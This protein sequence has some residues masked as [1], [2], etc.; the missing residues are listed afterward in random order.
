MWP[1]QRP[2]CGNG[3]ISRRWLGGVRRKW[4]ENGSG[5]QEYHFAR[6]LSQT[7]RVY[8]SENPVFLGHTSL[9][10]RGELLTSIVV[11]T[12]SE[13]PPGGGQA[14]ETAL[15][16]ELGGGATG[17]WEGDSRVMLRSSPGLREVLSKMGK[18]V[19]S[20]LQTNRNRRG[21]LEFHLRWISLISLPSTW[22][23]C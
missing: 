8:L 21:L 11:Q 17:P 5:R 22:A 16:D 18:P 19:M 14:G 1:A 7:P 12:L 10:N 13:R 23:G 15:S 2:S 3:R 6:Q 20:F 4:F 9:V